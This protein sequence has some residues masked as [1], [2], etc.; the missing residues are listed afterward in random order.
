MTRTAARVWIPGTNT[1]ERIVGAACALPP[2][3]VNSPRALLVSVASSSHILLQIVKSLHEMHSSEYFFGIL[4][5]ANEQCFDWEAGHMTLT[6]NTNTESDLVNL[7]PRSHRLY[8]NH[9]PVMGCLSKTLTPVRQ[10]S[11]LFLLFVS[12]RA[13]SSMDRAPDYGP[14]PA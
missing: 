9:V 12:S 5:Y 2:Q 10:I 7:T 13:R 1:R 6:G 8:K 3:G 11:I 4:I 14:V